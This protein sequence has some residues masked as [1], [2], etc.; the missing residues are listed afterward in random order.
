MS[1]EERQE[2]RA[3]I[4]AMLTTLDDDKHANCRAELGIVWQELDAAHATIARL[5]AEL[6]VYKPVEKCDVGGTL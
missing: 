1:P 2:I 5:E 3:R 6:L 4:K